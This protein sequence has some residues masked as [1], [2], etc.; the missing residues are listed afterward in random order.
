[1]SA[2]AWAEQHHDQL[3][4]IGFPESLLPQLFEALTAREAFAP[5]TDSAGVVAPRWCVRVAPVLWLT[6]PLRT[7]ARWASESGSWRAVICVPSQNSGCDD[8]AL[9]HLDALACA[10]RH[11]STPTHAFGCICPKG[12]TPVSVAWP[13]GGSDHTTKS[14]VRCEVTRDFLR[15][16]RAL[17]PAIAQHCICATASAPL[18]RASPRLLAR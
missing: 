7:G 8:E 10:I 17:P 14:D 13:V 3:E 1:M 4:A 18:H 15:G 5:S 16:A 11:S 2:S 6:A 12:S 9:A